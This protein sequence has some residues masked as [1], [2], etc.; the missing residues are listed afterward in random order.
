MPLPNWILFLKRVDDRIAK[1]ESWSLIAILSVMV[2]VSF[3]QVVL[4]NFFSTAFSWGDGLTRALV[5]W[6][7]LLGA[8]LAVKEGRYINIDTF[9]RILPEKVKRIVKMIVYIFAA[10]TCFFLGR[11]SVGFVESEKM[12]GTVYSI[13]IASWI[14]ELVIPV[15]FFFIAFRFVIKLVSLLA[16]GELEKAEW[17][18]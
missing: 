4:R 6:C 15:V 1:F 14:I 3:L 16:G 7:G 8:S 5:L 13:G 2:S 11:A 12:A 10:V 9:S 18:R 17:E